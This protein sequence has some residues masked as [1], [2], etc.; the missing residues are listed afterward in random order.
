MTWPQI[1]GSSH[2]AEVKT[3]EIRVSQLINKKAGDNSRLMAA[4]S[5]K[6]LVIGKFQSAEIVGRSARWYHCNGGQRDDESTPTFP[7]HEDLLVNW[8]SSTQGGMNSGEYS[9]EVMASTPGL[10]NQGPGGLSQRTR[11]RH[12]SEREGNLVRCALF[13]KRRIG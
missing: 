1:S 10:L 3:G 8:I 2:R 6:S 9:M 5:Q 12:S 4:V 7:Q 11:Y 13:R